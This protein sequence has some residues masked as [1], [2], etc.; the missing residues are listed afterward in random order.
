MTTIYDIAKKAGVSIATVSKVI[1]GKGKISKATKDHVIEV[2]KN[3]NYHPSTIAS[4][5]AG[6]KTFTL[7]LLI[8]DI[9]N[10]YFAEMAR[11]IED[12]SNQLG[13]SVVICNTDNNDH[14]IE[15][16]V[17]LLLQKKVDGIMIATGIN[18]K[19]ILKKLLSK[20]I[21][22]VLVAREM[23]LLAVH[24]IVVDDYVGGSIAASHLAALGH[25][26]VAILAESQKI[27]SSYERVR[28]FKQTLFDEGCTFDETMLKIC[29]YKIEDAKGKAAELFELQERPTAIFACNDM[30]AVG[31]IQAAKQYG[32]NVPSDVS[33]I[34]F[35]NT[36]LASVANP[37]L[38][39]I[40]QPIE[41]MGTAVINLIV[42]QLQGESSVKQRIIMR[43]ELI[44]RESTAAPVTVR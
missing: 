10:P 30:L 23:P 29:D 11:A 14:K 6:K 39:T 25:S 42:E 5:L 33:I 9:S 12:R 22:V 17:S 15:E 43:P 7:G 35:D 41:Q 37:P 20:D 40:A 31:A 28:G 38:T 19:E 44:I 26:H 8:P 1:N 16:Y 34:G 18:K 36:I 24:T 2:M 32:L 13:Y 21:P 27:K 4:A 3:L